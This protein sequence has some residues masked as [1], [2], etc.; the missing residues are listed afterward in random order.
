MPSHPPR[1]ERKIVGVDQAREM[2]NYANDR[3]REEARQELNVDFLH[4][5][6]LAGPLDEDL[7]SLEDLEGPNP[8]PCYFAKA[9]SFFAL[10]WAPDIPYVFI[11]LPIALRNWTFA[12]IIFFPTDFQFC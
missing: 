6:A 11:L 4:I 9:F 5:P 12:E 10:H 3:W 8:F 7:D 2:V 1:S